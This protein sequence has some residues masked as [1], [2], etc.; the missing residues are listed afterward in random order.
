MEPPVQAVARLDPVAEGLVVAGW[1][2]KSINI[3]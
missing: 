3:I 1:V 2:G